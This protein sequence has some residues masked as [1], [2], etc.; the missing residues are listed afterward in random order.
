MLHAAVREELFCPAYCLMP[1]HLHLISMGMRRESD[2]L[3]GIK[4]LRTHLEPALGGVRESQHQPHDHVLREKERMRNAF[5][6]QDYSLTAG[7][8]QYELG[9]GDVSEEIGRA[10]V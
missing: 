4:F 5:A 10:H 8:L 3:N 2:Q 7:L 6:R 9:D 1:D